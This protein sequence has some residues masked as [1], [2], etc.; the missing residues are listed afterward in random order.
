MLSLKS[1]GSAFA[2][3]GMALA[4]AF[5][6]PTTAQAQQT[7]E[8]QTWNG[9]CT[10]T[11]TGKKTAQTPKTECCIKEEKGLLAKDPATGK[12]Y[13]LAKNAD[14][15]HVQNSGGGGDGSST[16]GGSPGGPGGGGSGPG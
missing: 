16:G 12:F 7:T 3:V 1:I 5:I 10:S 8:L 13:R 11:I 14:S 6:M 4:P 15:C 2:S 9:F